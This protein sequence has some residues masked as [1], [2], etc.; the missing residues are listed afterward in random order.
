MYI[1]S[2]DYKQIDTYLPTNLL[3]TYSYHL[4]SQ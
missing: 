3:S 1:Y 4:S 2:V